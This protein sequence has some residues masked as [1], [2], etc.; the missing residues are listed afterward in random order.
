[1]VGWIGL[2]IK[3]LVHAIS[4]TIS[5]GIPRLALD[6][7]ARRGSKAYFCRRFNV[8]TAPCISDI[9]T[10]MYS[11]DIGLCIVRATRIVGMVYNCVAH[12]VLTTTW[13]FATGAG[14]TAASAAAC[15][16]ITPHPISHSCVAGIAA[17][18][19]YGTNVTIT[20]REIPVSCYPLY[21]ITVV[22]YEFAK[23]RNRIRIWLYV[24][25]TLSTYIFANDKISAV[26]RIKYPDFY[27]Y[28]I[29]RIPIRRQ[30]RHRQQ[31]QHHDKRQCQCKWFFHIVPLLFNVINIFLLNLAFILYILLEIISIACFLGAI[32]LMGCILIL[33][34]GVL[35]LLLRF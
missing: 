5:L 18:I 10:G 22:S 4:S 6:F 9:I 20:H 31:A 21:S 3:Q 23:C 11:I 15:S 26:I 34:G 12:R 25:I 2:N 7:K 27:C 30:R 14:S 16:I 29:I 17:P 28:F 35:W 32:I 13:F 24:L 1:M 19:Y 8:N 33:K